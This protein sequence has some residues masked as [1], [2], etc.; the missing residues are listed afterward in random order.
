M[1]ESQKKRLLLLLILFVIGVFVISGCGLIEKAVTQQA[2]QQTTP[3]TFSTLAGK[4]GITREIEL[5]VCAGMP[6]V[7]EVPLDSFCY[8]GLA[9]KHKD[10]AL[11][12]KMT[13]DVRK[14]CYTVIAQAS[15][16]PAL[17]EEAGTNKDQCYSEYA[18]Q[19][20]D[21]SACEK[22]VDVYQ[23]DNCYS[24]AANTL[25]DASYCDKVR[26]VPNK[27]NCYQNMA[28]R[29]QDETFCDKIATSNIKDS[30][31]QNLGG[32]YPVER[33]VPR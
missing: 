4:S 22:I 17:C 26:V 16:N 10:T 9:A 27:D 20:K 6:Q 25:A 19:T 11:C 29:L 5:E 32:V 14:S 15:N 13:S 21:V 31:Q 3:Q 1:S 2:G 8:I 18:R 33:E 28:M 24:D 12:Q 7:G 30:C 23:K